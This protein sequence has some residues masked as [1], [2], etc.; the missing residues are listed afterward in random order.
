[1][2]CQERGGSKSHPFPFADLT[3][4]HLVPNPCEYDIL[5]RPI[6]IPAKAGIQGCGVGC[7]MPE[8]F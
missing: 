2:N 6:V 5:K 4:T 7:Y 3:K 8:T 1:M